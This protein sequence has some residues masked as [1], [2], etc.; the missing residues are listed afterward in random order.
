MT[1]Y[2]DNMRRRWSG[3]KARNRKRVWIMSHLFADTDEELHAFAVDKLG[4]DRAWHQDEKWSHY[5]VT[6]TT[7]RLALKLG[8]VAVQWREV[9]SML[10]EMGKR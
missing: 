10:R 7:R 1:V 5:D 6:D 2:V 8:A 4:M 9:P 3:P